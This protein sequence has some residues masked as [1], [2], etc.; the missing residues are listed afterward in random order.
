MKKKKVIVVGG[1]ISGLSFAYECLQHKYDVTVVE[2]TAE[3]GGISKSITHND[4]RLDIGVHVTYLKDSQVLNKIKEIVDQEKWIRIKRQGKLY[5]NGKYVDWPLKYTALFQ[6][7]FTASL[8]ILWDQIVKKNVDSNALNYHDELLDLYGP[9]L[10]YLFFHPLTEK[11]LKTDPKYVHH[12]WAFSSLR[13]ATKLE[14]KAFLES[15]KYMT[16]TTDAESKKEYSIIRFLLKALGTNLDNEPFYYFSGGFGV[17]P[18]SYNEKILELGGEIVTSSSVNALTLEDNN[19]RQCTINEKVYDLDYLVWTV[20]PFELC[21]LLKI[22]CPPLEYLHTK[23]IYFFLKNCNMDH[24]VCY[25]A[26]PK[27]SSVRGTILSNISKSIIKN[28]N[29]S[30][31]VCLE[32][33]FKTR[34]EM[35]AN[36]DEMRKTATEDIINIGII[37]DIS[38]IESIYEL[39][40]PCT[41]PVLTK[42]YKEHLGELGNRT[43]IFNNLITF[44][45]QANFNYDNVDTVIKEAIN[46]PF[47]NNN[48]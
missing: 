6:L 19:I 25:Y 27:V 18:E 26:D 24:Q 34:E 44:G 5:I 17:L 39:N 48:L 12:D 14:D 45:R 21:S 40:V 29:V 15:N 30:D 22:E 36:S 46:H 11:F 2:N 35:F 1:G 13:S 28:H 10:Y 41:Y 37:K 23:F 33:T 16:E 20:S 7:P 42:D 38:S 8:K 43:S 4:C 31:L 32:Y 3:I 47:F 9:T